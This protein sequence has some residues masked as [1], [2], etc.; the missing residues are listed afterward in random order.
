MALVVLSRNAVLFL[1]AWE[2][3]SLSSWLLVTF[4]HEKSD[5]RRAGVTYLVATQIGTAFLLVLFLLLGS[6]GKPH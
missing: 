6:R 4:E 1:I 3:M 2:V 5:V